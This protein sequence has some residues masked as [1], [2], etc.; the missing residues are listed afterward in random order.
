MSD[1]AISNA[2]GWLSE[3]VALV[4]ALKAAEAADDHEAVDAK[5]QEIEEGPL[6]LQIRNGW[7]TPGDPDKGGPAEFELLLS[8]GGPALRVVGELDE[9]AQPWG[10][11]R[12]QWQDW[13]TPWTD[14]H[15]TTDE[16][17]EALS[18]YAACFY[19]GE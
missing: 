16:D 2:K 13:G 9:H 17:D 3:I 6:S 10:T 14:Y 5:R 15:E 19:F 4:A 1:H 7:Y 12:L 18:A 8:T 11:P